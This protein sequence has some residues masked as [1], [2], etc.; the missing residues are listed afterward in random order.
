MEKDERSK[1]LGGGGIIKQEEGFTAVTR[2]SH[3]HSPWRLMLNTRA[4]D[5]FSLPC[6][7]DTNLKTKPQRILVA[8]F[9]QPYNNLFLIY[10]ASLFTV[11]DTARENQ[12]QSR[13]ESGR[14]E[15]KEN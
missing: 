14:K 1:G 7:T 5:V 9:F 3:S 4:K 15:D 12:P 11:I 10:N 13:P 6:I 2:P 8:L